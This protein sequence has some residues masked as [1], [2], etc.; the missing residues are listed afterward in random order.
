MTQLSITPNHPLTGQCR[1]PGDQS[2]SHRALVF[3]ALAEGVSRVRNFLDSENCRA[4]M[5]VMRGLGVQ[6][7]EATP[8]ELHVYGRGLHGLQE[9]TDLLDCGNSTTTMG[10][11]TGLL[12]GQKFN[13]FLYGR[14][15]LRRRAMLPLVE[16]LRLMGASI[17]GR[18]DANLAPLGIKGSTLKSIEYEIPAASA[19]VKSCVLLAGLYAHGL[20][21]VREPEPTRDHTERMLQGMGA[22]VS[23][24]GSAIYSER[25]IRP[26]QPLE[27]TVPGDISLAAFL[28]AAACI[29][30]DSR[31]TIADVGVN[32]TRTGI[33]DVLCAMGAQIEI[34]NRRTEGGEPV[35]D[36]TVRFSDLHGATLGSKQVVAMIDELPVLVVA[37]TQA[38]GQTVL[39]GVQELPVQESDNIVVIVNELRKMGARIEPTADGLVVQGPT[40]LRG[41]PVESHSDPRLAMALAVAG[42]T[43]HGRTTIYG[44]EVIADDFPGFATTL[45]ALGA[46]I[47]VNV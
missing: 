17:M 36:V 40:Q 19:Q 20:T 37:A 5:R 4:T 25:P 8:T 3:G 32:V 45:Q 31:L 44:A 26:L 9:P 29:T 28:L 7:D 2:I 13:A 14:A 30:P 34:Q 16:P 41:A 15:P 18:Q 24:L 21:V 10:L 11:L 39:G 12:A 43:A 46:E 47:E 35:A 38:R 1:V 6:I 33:V 22:S 42:L 27:F 23:S